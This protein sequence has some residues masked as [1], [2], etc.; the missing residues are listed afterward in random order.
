[1]PCVLSVY[2]LSVYQA[3]HQSHALLSGCM[4][5]IAWNSFAILNKLNNCILPRQTAF[6]FNNVWV[7]CYP[8]VIPFKRYDLQEVMALWSEQSSNVT[9]L[10]QAR[11]VYLLK[12]GFSILNLLNVLIKFG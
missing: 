3:V 4:I 5:A 11:G 12:G 2:L 1:M 7:K 6:F 9:Q 10:H 8:S